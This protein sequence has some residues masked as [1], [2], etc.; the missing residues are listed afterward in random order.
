M[1]EAFADT[2]DFVGGQV[3][4]DHDAPQSHFRDQTLFQPLAEDP[5][6]HRAWEQLWGQ[7]AAMRQSGDKSGR[8]PVAMRDF[9]KELLAFVAPAM[10]SGH[11]CVGAG[12]I[13]EHKGGKVETG[14]TRSP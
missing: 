2:C 10:A 9:G 7:N 11:R 3:I 6:G 1:F 14:L 8:H 4:D 13:D 5:A 12:L